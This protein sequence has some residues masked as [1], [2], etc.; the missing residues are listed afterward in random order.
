MPRPVHIPVCRV[1]SLPQFA[2]SAYTTPWR[3]AQ[4]GDYG[5]LTRDAKGRQQVEVAKVE[6]AHRTAFTDADLAKALNTPAGRKA[7]I[8][9]KL[10]RVRRLDPGPIHIDAGPVNFFSKREAEAFAL[11]CVQVRDKQW[12]RLLAEQRRI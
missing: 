1:S 10:E 11:G 5:P 8:A 3:R 12:G 9:R 7:V 4:R 6:A 2:L